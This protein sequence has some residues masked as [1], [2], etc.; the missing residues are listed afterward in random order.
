MSN[1]GEK[2]GEGRKHKYL[3]DEAEGDNQAVCALQASVFSS[4]QW[5]QERDLP[6]R[7]REAPSMVMPSALQPRHREAMSLS[8]KKFPAGQ[9]HFYKIQTCQRS[10]FT[11]CQALLSCNVAGPV[12]TS[13]LGA[14]RGHGRSKL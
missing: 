10:I 2:E 12:L 9:I 11:K 5:G 13:F 4:T 14:L 6:G 7:Y 3:H 1:S 8:F